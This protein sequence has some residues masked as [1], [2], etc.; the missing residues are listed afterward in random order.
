MS[1]E[2]AE[3][4]LSDV[5]PL[6]VSSPPSPS[7]PLPLSSSFPSLTRSWPSSPLSSSR[8]VTAR[9]Y[10]SLQRSKEQELYHT[11]TYTARRP[12]VSSDHSVKARQVSF[13]PAPQDHAYVAMT[14][15]SRS[16][17]SD[18]LE[19]SQQA[20]FS[21]DVSSYKDGV[22][23]AEEAESE[24][25]LMTEEMD[26]KLQSSVNSSAKLSSGR[27]HIEEMENVRSHLQ[28]MLRSVPTATDTDELL[29][30]A[31][32]HLH[33]DSYESDTTSHLL[34]AALTLGGVE[35]LFPRYSRLR[36]DVNAAPLPSVPELQVIRESLERERARRKALASFEK[37]LSEAA[38]MLDKEQKHGEK[39]QDLNKQQERELEEVRAR[40]EEL[41]VRAE[42]RKSETEEE[43]AKAERLQ[44]LGVA[45]QAELDQQ[46]QQSRH[47]LSQLQQDIARLTQQLDTERERVGLEVQLR[48]EAQSAVRQL[49]QELEETRRER[50]TS[51]VDRALDQARFEA[52]RSQW[53]VELRLCVEQQVTE[54]LANIQQENSAATAKL[55][56]QHRRQLLDLS[57]RHERELSAQM[58]EFR[59]QLEE[60]DEKQQQLTLH[61]NNKVA[62]LQEELVSQEACKRRLETQREELVSRL[63]G[64]MRTHWTEALRLLN[65][66]EQ[67]DGIFS[68]LSLWDGS[69]P[70]SS[71]RDPD[72][73]VCSTANA[74]APAAPQA[75]VLHLSRERERGMKGEEEVRAERGRGE[76]DFSLIS[77]SHVF[78]PLEP[79]LDNTNLTGTHQTVCPTVVL[80]T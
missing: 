57:A 74:L 48:E 51:R 32:Q 4:L 33:D 31:S 78:S 75:V 17:S 28:T 13:K 3:V 61:F 19:E 59:A 15:A 47:S 66:Q 7:P 65:S 12:P 40:A 16:L 72:S 68:P 18:R 44:T 9:L 62:A 55:R 22:S 24:A 54:R 80:S 53:E 5:E 52:Q 76:S 34:S 73:S 60:K 36:A 37:S 35:E 8:Q 23:G 63:Q 21:L 70:H 42:E 11:G 67:A 49:Q 14:P 69:K 1:V 71:P 26:L 38:E 20:D 29:R 41:R 10:S 30:P 6:P 50:D 43:R 2:A 77:H 39:L 25:E 56:E 46:K 64:M 27:R 45:L 79:V 58:E